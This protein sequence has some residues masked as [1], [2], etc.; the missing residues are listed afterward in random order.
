MTD[1][2]LSFI[3]VFYGDTAWGGNEIYQAA[4]SRPGY[5]FRQSATQNIG[6]L[7]NVGVPGLFIYR[8]DQSSVIL[9]TLTISGK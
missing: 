9:P 5:S 2:T 4:F 1:G 6:T 8:V 3:I 7:S